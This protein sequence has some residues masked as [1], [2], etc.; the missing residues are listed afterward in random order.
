MYISAF[1][2]VHENTEYQPTFQI[3]AILHHML[4]DQI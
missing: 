4:P 2:I 3:I 1:C